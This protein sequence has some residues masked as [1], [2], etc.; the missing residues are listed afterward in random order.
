MLHQLNI[1]YKLLCL[2]N[3][4]FI[5]KINIRKRKMCWIMKLN[6]HKKNAINILKNY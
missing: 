1:N 5:V 4:S 2:F 6:F 3:M